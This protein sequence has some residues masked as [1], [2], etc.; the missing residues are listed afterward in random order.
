MRR[1]AVL[2]ATGFGIGRVPLAPATAASLAVAVLLFA[3]HLLA[4]SALAPLPV[5]LALLV[6]L[7]FAI[8][9]SGEAEKELGHD[10]HPIVVDEVVGMLAAVVGI[11]R[12]AEPAP[13]L[14]LFLAFAL[15]RFFDIVKPFPIGASQRLPGG[16]GI[17]VDDLLAGVAT[18]LV[19]RFL[20]AW[21]WLG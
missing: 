12:L 13:A 14:L 18:N 4:P 2:L 3:I 9:S 6:L 20:L 15:F 10:A 5:A 17:V 16:W 11:G 7:P 21:G 19:L 1:P 8:W